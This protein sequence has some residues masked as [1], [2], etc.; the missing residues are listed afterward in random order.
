MGKKIN[1]RDRITQRSIGFNFRQILFFN[2]YPQFTPDSWCREAV[3]K[4]IKE[5]DSKFLKEEEDEKE[6]RQ[7]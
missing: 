7:N 1:P 3:D 4:Q 5:I 6:T 2:E